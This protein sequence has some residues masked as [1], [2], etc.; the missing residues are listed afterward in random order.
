[1]PGIVGLITK[2][3]PQ[4]AETQLL[5]MV[6]S[7]RHERFYRV[8][9]WSNEGLGVYVGWAIPNGALASGLP[10]RNR[11]GDLILVFSG[12]EYSGPEVSEQ[13]NRQT[14]EGAVGPFSYLLN[15]CKDACF[16]ANLNGRFQGLA[17]DMNSGTATLFNDRFGMSRIYYHEAKDDFYFAAEAKAILKVLP[18]LRSPDPRSM[19]EFV[20]CGC[21]MENRTLFKGIQ[22][23]PPG[24]AWSFRRGVLEQKR[25]YFHAREWED[26]E[27]LDAEAFYQEL[28]GVLTR[29]LPRY[30][31]GPERVG[32]SLTGGLDTRMIMA[33][34]RA[35]SGSLP[36]YTFAGPFRECED[37]VIA[38]KV[39][40][41][42]E[43]PHQVIPI[44]NDFLA[45]FPQ[46]AERTVYLS[47]GCAPV[48][49]ASDLW[50]NEQ[51]RS[52][53]PVRMTGNYGSE[54]LRWTPAFKPVEPPAGLFHPDLLS[55]M[56]AAR[57][58]YAGIVQGHPVSFAA[59]RQAPWHHYGLLALEQTQV[60][61]RSPY[62]DNEFVRTAFRAPAPTYARRDTMN[63]DL[64]LRIIA[65]G[66]PELRKIA[67][68]RGLGGNGSP[69]SRKL[70]RQMLE[71]TFRAEYAFDY[72]MP[73][74]LAQTNY[75]LSPLRLER[76]FLGRHK[77]AH[78]RVW[79]RDALG[80]YVREMLL[81]AKS[82]SR[83]YLQ[84]GQVTSAV[85]AHLR[86][87]R[88]HT[89][90]IH[91]LLTLELVQRLFF[92]SN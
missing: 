60:S 30:F 25:T 9:T 11:A 61:L 77:F 57:E 6:E 44:G 8:G 49:R 83:P 40:R 33:W 10:L 78:Y 41:L 51:A 5:K 70:S 52:I 86:G 16:P 43:Q 1:M 76:V 88:N 91:A 24:S 35:P 69:L 4:W 3:Q 37:L 87:N 45:R 72:G 21:V 92:D 58:T 53:A 15:S 12:E 23:L 62:L 28:Q 65:A 22:V 42:C 47:D 26:Q 85:S 67:T 13:S 63:T 27:R 89:V 66:S 36:C 19:G 82:L 29:I 18:E 32:M 73:Q 84:K 46:Y 56:R 81:D 68:D 55:Q 90:E 59:F 38:R 20:A 14:D 48:Y 2:R 74:W 31:A 75:A 80:Q 17:A 71:F 79:Y 7:L 64:C 54:V 39:A 34:H 50:A